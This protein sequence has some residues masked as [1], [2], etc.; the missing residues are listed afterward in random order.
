[1]NFDN[2]EVADKMLNVIR[3]WLDMGI[4]GFRADAVPYLFEREDTN[5]ENL[6]ETHAYLKLVRAMMEAEYPETILLGEANQWPHDLRP[7]FGGNPDDLT[8]PGD[9]FHLSFHFPLMPRIFK[10][11]KTGDVSDIINIMRNTPSIPNNCQ[12][13]V[14]LRNHDELTLEMAAQGHKVDIIT[15]QIIDPNWSEFAA[16]LDGYRAHKNP[17]IVRL[18]CGPKHFLPK[19]SL[20]PCL[21]EWATRILDFYHQEDNLP[22]IF[23]A[24]Y[25]DGGLAG[26][27]LQAQ[28]DIHPLHLHRTLAGG[29]ED[30]QAES[31]AGDSGRT[32]PTVP[33]QR[34]HPGQANGNESRRPHHRQH[35]AG[36][37]GAI[38]PSR[39]SQRS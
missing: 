28:S 13:C 15:R 14:F 32:G 9:E 1:L 35:P 26:A 8:V 3:Y 24:H 27:L 30:G 19:E 39:L 21:N 29:A 20:W 18:P 11:L 17:R 25:A 12:W 22:H 37:D 6:Q 31:I 2:P 4:D 36:A 5:C 7:Y 10:S 16:P 23:T 38:P 34:A 33:L